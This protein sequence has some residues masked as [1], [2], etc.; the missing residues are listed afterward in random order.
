VTRQWEWPD[1]GTLADLAAI[2]RSGPLV[3]CLTNI[4][5]A[6][7]TANAL[8]AIGGAPIMVENSQESGEFA[9]GADAVL[10]N[11]GTLSE[12][13]IEAMRRASASARS[14][15]VPWILDPVAAGAIA[16]RTDLSRDL[17]GNGPAV[18]RG[19]GSE[20]MCVAGAGAPG[21]GVESLA[22]AAEALPAAREI[23]RQYGCVVAVSGEVDHLTDGETDVAVPGGH[24]LMTRV[25]GVGCILGSLMAAFTAVQNDRLRA[26]AGASALLAEAGSRAAKT[27][28]AAGAG[29]GTFAVALID[30]LYLIAEEA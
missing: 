18:L 13:R 24:V 9:K 10:V 22:G 11:M 26:A 8:L 5:V 12:D 2:R 29:S 19:N 17:L 21:K 20:V 4:V 25:T 30:H 1:S 6:N 28:A 23:A 27:T 3:H 7:F 16:A 14:A 15:G